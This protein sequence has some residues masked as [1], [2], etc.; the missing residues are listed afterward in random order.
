MKISEKGGVITV[1][2][3]VDGEMYT[4]VYDREYI[5]GY[6]YESNTESMIRAELEKEFN[7]EDII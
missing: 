2:F 4:R 1:I 5:D 6:C 7:K 3:E